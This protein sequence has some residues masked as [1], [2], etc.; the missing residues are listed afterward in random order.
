VTAAVRSAIRAKMEYSLA[1]SEN[2]DFQAGAATGRV[3]VEDSTMAALQRPGST[4][5]QENYV[6]F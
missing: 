4:V 5:G 2:R 6:E 1:A 3:D